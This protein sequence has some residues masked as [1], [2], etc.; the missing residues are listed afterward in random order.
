MITLSGFTDEIWATLPAQ[1]HLA[2]R[3]GLTHV[4]LRRVGLSGV[5]RFSDRRLAR[6][7]RLLAAQQLGISSIATPIGKSDVDA[8]ATSD[9][10]DLRRAAV[11][12]HR[13]GTPFVRVFSWFT[14]TPDADA[15]AVLDKMAALADVADAEGVTLLHENEKG[16]YGDRPERCLDLVR[17]TGGRL[18]LVFD[19]ANFVQCGVRPHDEAWPRLAP[20]V[21]ALHAK[22]A[23]TR[24]RRVVPCGEGDGQWP[25]LAAALAQSGW[26]GF[27][28]LEP[29]LGLGGRGG[30]VQPRRWASALDAL[31]RV[32]ADA[33]VQV[34]RRAGSPSAG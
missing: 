4:E 2:R 21:A 33:G 31:R 14:P 7:E 11:L 34:T 19:P 3:L 12:A 32:W 1:V 6:V 17:A 8:P 26:D 18:R 30:P 9:A 5:L 28:S 10:D 16:V 24:T 27:I 23:R 25:Q 29:H 20:H 15:P 13:F 22:D